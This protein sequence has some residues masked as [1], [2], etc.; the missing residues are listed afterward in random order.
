VEVRNAREKIVMVGNNC[1]PGV[2]SMCTWGPIYRGSYIWSLQCPY[3]PCSPTLVCH[4]DVTGLLQIFMCP[5]NGNVTHVPYAMTLKTETFGVLMTLDAIY[6]CLEASSTEVTF[7]A[8]HC[9]ESSPSD[10]ASSRP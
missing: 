5:T 7:G 8:I 4:Y 9:A 6:H 10:P 1:P 3:C 2:P